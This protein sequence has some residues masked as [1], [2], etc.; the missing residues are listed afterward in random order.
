M[1]ENAATTDHHG[2][3]T[4][5]EWDRYWEDSA[6]DRGR[7]A[8]IA[9]LYRRHVISRA[10]RHY[11]RRYFGDRAGARYLHAGC[12]SGE[13]DRRIGY[14]NATFILLDISPQALKIARATTDLPNV[15]FVCG[16]VFAPPFRTAAIDGV[17]NLGVMEHF[18]EPDIRRIF[19][20]LERV[21]KP[22]ALG[23]VFWPPVFGSSVI[24]LGALQYVAQTIFQ[25]RMQFFPD[26]VSLFRSGR[27]VRRLLAHTG[28]RLERVHF[29][30]R[31][32][33]TYALVVVRRSAEPPPG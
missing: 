1:T 10:V 28:L 24:G 15:H 20:G 16:D 2:H 32:L 5:A 21:L 33:F 7:F 13:S 18:H 8:V 14:K 30:V 3:H 31:D 4:S 6:L 11:F 27:V 12:G 25:R 9:K 23:L 22:G 29:S 19:T 17:W 26:E